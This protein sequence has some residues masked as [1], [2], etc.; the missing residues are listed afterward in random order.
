MKKLIRAAMKARG[1][2]HAPYSRFKV[3]AALEAE[4]GRIFTGCNVENASFGATCCAER[5]AL[6]KAVSEGKK[7]FKR[8]AIVAATEKP[9]PPCGICRQALYEFSPDLEV[10]M[11]NTRGKTLAMKLSDLLPVGFRERGLGKK[12]P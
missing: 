2:A 8:I 3:G 6:F 9:C 1:R 5:T 10:V 7:K 4:G 12:R 11:A